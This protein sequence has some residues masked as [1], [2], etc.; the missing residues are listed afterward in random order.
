MFEDAL[1]TR[2]KA[3]FDLDKVTYD[4]V[5][6]AQEQETIFIEITSSKNRI[7]DGV[8]TARVEG[9]LRVFSS[10]KKLPYGYFSK[11]I[12]EADNALT[13]DLFFYDIEENSNVFGNIAERNM[14]FIYFFNSQYD[15]NLG[16]I[17][18][19]TF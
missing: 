18:S 14:S 13:R 8:E 7:R 17:T 9:L 11:K 1:K 12:Q 2:L 10:S 16:S 3:I 19:V 6:Q 15:P 5:G 4:A